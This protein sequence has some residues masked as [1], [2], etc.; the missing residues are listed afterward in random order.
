MDLLILLSCLRCSRCLI[1]LCKSSLVSKAITSVH[2]IS[3]FSIIGPL[4]RR[5]G[6]V[7]C[8]LFFFTTTFIVFTLYF[9]LKKI[10]FSYNHCVK[11]VSGPYF[12]SFRPEKPPYLDTS[13]AVNAHFKLSSLKSFQRMKF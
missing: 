9:M 4:I 2:E 1:C 3:Q 13:W 10:S 8:F 5:I 11:I 6:F 7:M 12:P